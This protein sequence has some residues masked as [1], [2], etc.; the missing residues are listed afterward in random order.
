MEEVTFAPDEFGL[1]GV[2]PPPPPE[3]RR[4]SSAV[5]VRAHERERRRS[6]LKMLENK[7]R[8]TVIEVTPIMA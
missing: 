1:D 5:A 2:P 3:G 7:I 4:R 6:S 8:F